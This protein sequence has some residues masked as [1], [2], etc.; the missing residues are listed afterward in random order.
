MKL[1]QIIVE[2]RKNNNLTQEEF[3]KIFNV[4][5]QTV[6]NWENEKSYPDLLTLIKISDNYGYSLDTMLK[7]NPDMT[8]AMN[9]SIAA[10]NETQM[11]IKKKGLIFS[12][13]GILCGVLTI[14]FALIDRPGNRTFT[15]VL[16][17]MF[18]LINMINTEFVYLQYK[19]VDAY[20]GERLKKLT[21]EDAEMVRQLVKRDMDVE[22][23]KLV[24][25]TT[26]A[27]LVEAKTFVDETKKIL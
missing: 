21:D 27:G 17:G 19:K 11:K 13:I 16:A 4:T 1:G 15:F 23:V 6:S 25:K 10:T 20:P 24:R 14:V 7:E 26:G 3:A 5:R 2:I 18:V 8:E 9:R 22:A 12:V